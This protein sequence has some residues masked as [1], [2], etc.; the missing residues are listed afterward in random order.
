MEFK[1]E[2]F[3]YGL[4]AK[5]FIIAGPIIVFGVIGSVSTGIIYYILNLLK[6]I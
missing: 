6:L 5:M 1:T 3:I 2:G 4:A